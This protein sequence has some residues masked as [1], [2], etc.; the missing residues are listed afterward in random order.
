MTSLAVYIH[1]PYCVSKCPYC[2]FNSRAMGTVDHAVWARAYGRELEHYAQALPDRRIGSVYFGGGTPSLMEPRTVEAVLKKIAA[3]WPLAEDIEITL[4][5]NPSSAETEKFKA[6]RAAGVHRL[7]LGVQS[8]RDDAL[9]FLGRAH[10][11]DEA[12][13]AIECAAEIFTRF[14]FDLI[15]G[16]NNQSPEIWAAELREALA[17]GPRHLS[18]Y[19]LTIEEGTRFAALAKECPLV[20]PEDDVAAM[21]EMTHEILRPAGLTAYEISNYAAPG[22]ESRHNLTYWHYDDYIGIGPGAHGRYVSGNTRYA[23]ENSA[24]PDD[25][26]QRVSTIGHGRIVEATL[27]D[28][29]A[30]EEA[31]MMGLRLTEGIGLSSWQEKFGGSLFDFLPEAKVENLQEKGLLAREGKSL[32]ATKDGLERLN[33]VLKYLLA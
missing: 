2:D 31:L 30:Q 32:R 17:F 20:A 16:R 12:K 5:A 22:E 1:W 33:G 28:V 7:S 13:R 8:F 23:T 21:D 18:L 25:W 27:D 24:D 14:S 11:A 4:E 26:M 3:L 15:Y 10:D 9:R 6:F 29:T 19:Q